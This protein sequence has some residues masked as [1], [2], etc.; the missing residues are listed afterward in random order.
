MRPLCNMQ[1]GH[2]VII[3]DNNKARNRWSLARVIE[4]YPNKDDGLVCSVKVAIEDPDLYSTGKRLHPLSILERPIQ[5]LVL[6]PP[7]EERMGFPHGEPFNKE[8]QKK[9]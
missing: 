1:V 7:K 9:D 8:S 6:L 2:V 5:R 3:K 4:M